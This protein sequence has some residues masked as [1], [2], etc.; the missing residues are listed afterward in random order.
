MSN[1][2]HRTKI[3]KLVHQCGGGFP[4]FKLLVRACRL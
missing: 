1:K 4:G 3:Q 2:T